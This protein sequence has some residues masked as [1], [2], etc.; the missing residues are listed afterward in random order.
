VRHRRLIG[1][2][3]PGEQV[4]AQRLGE[5]HRSLGDDRDRAAQLLQRQRAAVDPRQAD[6]T[7]GRVV[8]AGQE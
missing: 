6:G 3:T 7:A 8:M 2:G 1:I 4:G 5:E